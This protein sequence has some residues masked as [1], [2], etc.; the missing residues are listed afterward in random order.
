[1][2]VNNVVRTITIKGVSD[3][4]EKLTKDVNNLAAAQQNVAVVSDTSAKRVL[5]L[6]DAWKKQTLK[7]D[8]A[9][10]S[11]A[12]IAR[13]SKIAD[14]A[15][16]EGLITQQQHA[17]RLNLI[18]QRY[19]VA[20]AAAGKFTT[21]NGL[22]R[23]EL[24]N[25]SRQAQDV[26]VSLA[27]GQSP[28]LVL[29]QQG[30]Q[31]ADVFASSTGSVRG[32]F[33][34]AIGWAG[35]FVTSA[36]GVTAGIVTIGA[37]ALFMGQ[38]FSSAQKDIDRALSGIGAGSGANRGD[39]N[40]IAGAAASPTGL[41]VSEAREAATAFAATGKIYQ[42]NIRSATLITKDFARAMGVD[43]SDATKQLAKDLSGDLVG[44]AL[45]WNA[46]LGFA[47]NKTIDY[48]QSLVSM[49]QKQQAINAL[50]TAAAPSI[51]RMAAETNKWGVAWDFVANKV[52]N[53]GDAIGRAVSR[54]AE[55]LTGAN[56]GGF[57]DQERL[58]RLRENRASRS[59][60]QFALGLDAGAIRALDQEIAKLEQRIADMAK[61]G[62]RVRFAQMSLEARDFARSVNEG[63]AQIERL[64]QG[65]ATIEQLQ[66][67]R[68]AGGGVVD[69]GLEQAAQIARVQLALAME[70]EQVE[71][72]KAQVISQNAMAYQNVSASTAQVLAQLRDQL[73]VA[74]AVTGA[75]QIE[76]QHRATTNALLAQGKTL[77]DA[78]AIADAQRAISLAQVNAEAD[79]TLKNLQ[80]QAELIRAASEEERGRIKAAQEYNKLIEAGVD[81]QKA[82]AIAAQMQA[83]ARSE[84]DAREQAQADQDAARAAQDHASAAREAAAAS[85]R[86]AEAAAEA[87]RRWEAAAQ[88]LKF[89]PFYLL[90]TLGLMDKLFN[91]NQGGKSQFNPEGYKS[92][93]SVG[94]VLQLKPNDIANSALASGASAYDAFGS[95]LE[96][97]LTKWMPAADGKPA[98]TTLD[99]E[100]LQALDQLRDL[101]S[102]TQEQIAAIQKEWMS[103]ST[104]PASIER[105]T[106]MKSLVDSLKQLTD[107]TNQNTS[108]TSAMTDVLSPFYSSD[109]RRT[110]LGFRA[111][112]GGGIMSP[113]GEIPIN[114]YDGGGIASSPQ[115][116]VFGEGRT[117]EAY[118]PV[119]SGRIPVE[120][121]QPANSN[122][123]TSVVVHNHF[124][125][126]VTKETADLMKRT[127][128][129][130][131]QQMKRSFG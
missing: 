57:E 116:A 124:N 35:R 44:A 69:P 39:I 113:W 125:G 76:A 62:E 55:R 47:D 10:R 45:K 41:S 17:E 89:L 51:G 52:S 42:D 59:G 81:A 49:G 92:T 108:A 96:G 118:V 8:E 56:F 46:T 86:I 60:G 80:D 97:G 87:Q 104:L 18:T 22:A 25:L 67:R 128:F 24:I 20:S 91:S 121:R 13:E 68:V 48:I 79:R 73:G 93:S 70:Q 27:S 102:S 9:A 1:M 103:L 11:Q 83:N 16:R 71:I 6:E 31:I 115:V 99:T 15:L 122:K 94:P 106:Q 3:G 36:V 63:T 61:Q 4:V 38:S 54:G 85:E 77:V 66:A 107:A 84:Q 88:A 33:G 72:R 64:S 120:M 7:L 130:N 23:H 75:A 82:G 21:Q 40:R 50:I 32:F 111:F 37:A 78:I 100:R 74:Q 123:P 12:N 65:L 19:T 112:A 129:Q 58:T 53:A 95:L 28:L 26:G 117:P 109:P 126:P 110:T 30:S 34:Q 5:S 98:S 119:P 2:N 131:A 127:G 14:N 114:R 101:M 90:D 29:A 43:A 105:D